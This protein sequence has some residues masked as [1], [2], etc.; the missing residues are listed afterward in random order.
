MNVNAK[1]VTAQIIKNPTVVGSR[2]LK[3]YFANCANCHGPDAMG[4]TMAPALVKLAKNRRLTKSFL[5]DY[6]VGHKREP[7][8]GSMPKFKQ[9]APEDR[10]AIAEWLLTLD[11]PIEKPVEA[12]ESEPVPVTASA[13]PARKSEKV[14]E[15]VHPPALEAAALAPPQAFTANCAFCHGPRG[16]GNIGPSLVG[17]TEKPNRSKDDLIKLLTNPRSY[18][19]KD[20]MPANFPTLSEEDRKQIIE[21]LSKY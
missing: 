13:A 11:K 15:V 8:P 9:L 14:K 4:G 1:P 6:L 19:L 16:E 10:E 18:G 3:I 5:V 17:I 7:S 21:W 2:V 12:M 20:P